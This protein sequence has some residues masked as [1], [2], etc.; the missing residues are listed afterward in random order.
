M[1]LLNLTILLLQ[2]QD[3]GPFKYHIFLWMGNKA[4]DSSIKSTCSWCIKLLQSL[5]GRPVVYRES[6]GHESSLFRS[7][8]RDVVIF[9]S[10]SITYY[11]DALEKPT[12]Y[13]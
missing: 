9:E 10:T 11:N 4:K 12:L 13:R 3:L 6:E 2:I 8:F 7:T 5:P 1:L